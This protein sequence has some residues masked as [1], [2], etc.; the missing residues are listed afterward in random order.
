M[1]TDLDAAEHAIRQ[2]LRYL[3]DPD[4]LRDEDAIAKAQEDVDNAVDPLDKLKALAQ[5]E[6]VSVI[7]EEPL[8]A[9]FVDYAKAWAHAVNVPVSA[10]V[11]LH[12]PAD[13][14][15]EAGFDI[16]PAK[17]NHRSSGTPSKRAKPVRLDDI[18]AWITRQSGTFTTVD[19]SAGV[20]GSPMTQRAAIN[21]LVEAGAVEGLGPLPTYTGVGR[22]PHHYRCVPSR[23]NE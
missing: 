13:V 4:Q 5:L 7:H 23:T 8:R 14:L 20:G 12:V 9:E 6:Q 21:Q 18:K 2:Y 11:A 19:I 22:A 3:D 17:S 10:F 1:T 16:K 15:D